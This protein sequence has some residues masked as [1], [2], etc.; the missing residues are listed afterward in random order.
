MVLPTPFTPTTKITTGVV[1][2]SSPFG[3]LFNIACISSFSAVFTPSSS[4]IFSNL[5]LSLNFEIISVDVSTPISDIINISSNSS[6]N[7]SSTFLKLLNTLL[8]LLLKESRVFPK[9]DFNLSKKPI[10]VPHII[11]YFYFSTTHS[12]TQEFNMLF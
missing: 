12:P 8:T 3:T 1:F 7:S 11:L 6:N 10:V 2:N 4:E 5:I 9:P